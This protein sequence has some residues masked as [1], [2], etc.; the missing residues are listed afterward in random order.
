[1]HSHGPDIAVPSRREFLQA[2]AASV[3]GAILLS[4]ALSAGAYAAG[5]DTIKVALIGC[6]A[7]GTGAIAQALS[8]PQ[9]VKL[10]A[11]A[12]AFSD[13]LEGSLAELEKGA[14]GSYNLA[15]GTGFGDKLDVPPE[16]RFVGL[17]AYRKAIDAGVDVVIITGPPGFRPQHF[18]YA[19]AAGKHVFM[20]KP[21]ATDPAGVRRVLAAAEVA[22]RKNLKIGV[23]LQ[24]HHDPG[25]QETV[26][27]IQD[28]E[29][30]RIVTLRCYWNSGPPAKRPVARADMTEL[31]YQVRNWYFFDWLSGDHICEQHIHNIDVCNWVKQAYPVQAEGMGGRQVRTGKEYGNIFD[32]HFVEFTYADGTKMF[33]QCRQIPGCQNRVAEFV[34][35][36]DGEAELAGSRSTLAKGGKKYW[37]PARLRGEANVSPYQ[38]EHNV[39]FDAI[40]NDKPH[41]EVEY[42]ARS[43]MT[44][45]LG[46]FATYSGKAVTWDE[47]L[48]SDHVLTTDA[49]SWEAKAPVSPLADGSYAIA[50]PGVTHVV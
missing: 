30:G 12:D 9:P 20:E 41:H 38:I 42:G 29:I 47:A 16:R 2:T 48:G 15:K 46:R 3:G 21:V 36:T 25:Y 6:G 5:G 34:E 40:A 43:T 32:H 45:I 31:E 37:R 17:D 14:P 44:A 33:S 23:G 10:W 7:R 8:T 39:L 13:R 1:M 27:R 50:M 4:P 22:K 26:Q 24:R 28:G 49:E 19:V 11:M 35:A 18:E